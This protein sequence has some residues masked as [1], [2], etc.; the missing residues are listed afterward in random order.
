MNVADSRLAQAGI[1]LASPLG[2]ALLTKVRD[3]TYL[4]HAHSLAVNCDETQFV[5]T[6]GAPVE[7]LPSLVHSHAVTL[8]LLLRISP[9]GTPDPTPLL[10]NEAFYTLTAVTTVSVSC[11]LA[12]FRLPRLVSRQ[13]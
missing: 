7:Q 13:N 1:F 3:Y 6:F 5:A 10:Y 12:A 2:A 9:P 11:Y 4:K 8:P